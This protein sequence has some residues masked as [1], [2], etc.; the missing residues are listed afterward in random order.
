MPVVEQGIERRTTAPPAYE[1]MHDSATPEAVVGFG[2]EEVP[3]VQHKSMAPTSSTRNA[4][5]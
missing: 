5:T 4:A 3:L 2:G 1:S